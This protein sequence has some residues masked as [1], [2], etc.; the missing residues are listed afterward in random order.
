MHTPSL[1]L[2]SHLPSH[3]PSHIPSHVPSHLPSQTEGYQQ[4]FIGLKSLDESGRLIQLTYAGDHLQFSDEFWAK[5]V[6]AH[7]GP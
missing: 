3:I 5:L 2:R 6:L 7:L 1:H 4:D